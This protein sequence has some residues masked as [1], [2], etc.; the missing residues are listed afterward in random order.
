VTLEAAALAAK[1]GDTRFR[2]SVHLCPPEGLPEGL[3][4]TYDLPQ[5]SSVEEEARHFRSRDAVGDDV[6][7]LL[8]SVAVAQVGTG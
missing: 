2:V 8:V 3:H 1:E 6:G 5:L 4:E 7:H